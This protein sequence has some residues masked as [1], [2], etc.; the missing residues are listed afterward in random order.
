M[1]RGEGRKPQKRG[2]FGTAHKLPSGRYRAM[3]FGP[4][5]RRYKADKT[6]LTEKD[7]RGWLSLRQAEIIAKSW[8]PPEAHAAQTRLTLDQYSET[9]LEQRD[10]KART[11]EHYRKL[12]DE[13]VLPD[14]GSRP[15]G[16]ITVDDVRGW[17]AK[18]STRGTPTLRAHAYG[19]L[20]TIMA[21]AVSDGK[22]KANPCAIRGAGSARRVHK[23]RPATLDEIATITGEM[24]KQYQAMVLLAAWCALRFGELTE[25][26]RRDIIIVEPTE[27]QLRH[28]VTHSE[29]PPE[30]YGIVRVER[31]VVRTVE[32]FTVTSPKSAAGRRDVEIPPHL[33]PAIKAHLATHVQPDREALLFP[34]IKINGGHMAPASLY[35]HFYKARSAAKRDDLRWHDLRHSGA[36]LAAA[37][38][39]TLAELMQRLGHS[40]PAAAMKY[41]HISAGRDR[42]IAKLLSKMAATDPE[43]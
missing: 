24:P 3:Y 2:A 28:A 27:E 6:F 4:D 42:Q 39:A 35:R 18:M 43:K 1:V 7:A 41:Q 19:L 20:R 10:L 22:I 26:R 36:V 40:T 30:P 21:T 29:D 15:I 25:L 8:Q 5:G 17:H 33:L 37:T 23:I 38:G 31:A 13:H 9:W 34:A 32:G 11:R 12:L 16:S 14:L